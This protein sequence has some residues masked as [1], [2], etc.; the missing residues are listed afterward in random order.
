M[1]IRSFDE[2]IIVTF[3]KT[4]VAHKWIKGSHTVNVYNGNG[5]IDCYT[6]AW[7]KDRPS[8]LDFTTA[9]ASY[10]SEE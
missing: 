10:L 2:F 9:L 7:E 1:R 6:F 8:M 4:A 3:P 5:N